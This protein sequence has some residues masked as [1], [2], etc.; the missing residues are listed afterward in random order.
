MEL[1]GEGWFVT[2]SWFGSSKTASQEQGLW[3]TRGEVSPPL[4]SAP[5]AE[6]LQAWLG[7]KPCL[8]I[9]WVSPVLSLASLR[10]YREMCILKGMLR[11]VLMNT[12]E[13]IGM[14]LKPCFA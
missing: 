7:H 12:Y 1:T 6:C 4:Y 3:N 8:F 2:H 9:I 10:K 11:T 13:R 5:W 14:A